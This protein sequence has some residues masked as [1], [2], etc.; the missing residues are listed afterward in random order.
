MEFLNFSR[1]F[2]FLNFSEVVKNFNGRIWD[3]NG[4]LLITKSLKKFCKTENI[5]G[6]EKC[7]E[8]DILSMNKCYPITWQKW[9]TLFYEY[10]A[11]EAMQ[12]VK[13]SYFV[14]LWN[15]KSKGAKLKTTSRA[16]FNQLAAKHCP[17]VHQ[18]NLII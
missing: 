6:I 14:H 4:P 3:I 16:S 18:H 9:H 2:N 11:D 5:L 1:Y 15:A 8:F 7:K 17:R 10:Y 12:T 13:D